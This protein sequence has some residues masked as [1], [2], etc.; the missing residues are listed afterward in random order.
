MSNDD[1]RSHWDSVYT[2]KNEEEVS[3]FEPSPDLSLELLAQA[4]LKTDMAVVDVGGGASRL[5][6]ALV[7]LQVAEIA[8]LD[9]SEAALRTAQARL[10]SPGNVS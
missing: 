5:V 1:R 7:R 10:T 8:V 4:G 2:A 3:W 9:L 6:D